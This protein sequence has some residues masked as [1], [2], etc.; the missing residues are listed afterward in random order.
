MKSI[1]RSLS[2]SMF[3]VLFLL[4][5]A[6]GSLLYLYAQR[7]LLSQFDAQLMDKALDFTATSEMSEKGEYEFELSKVALPKFEPSSTAEYY[8]VWGD[9]GAVLLRSPSLEGRDLPR[10]TA[11]A[12]KILLRDISL[13]DGR[14]GRAVVLAFVPGMEEDEHGNSP[15]M[16]ATRQR[17]CLVMARSRA[18]LDRILHVLLLVIILA[19]IGLPAIAGLLVQR[20]ILR[21]LRPLDQV[22][23]QAASIDADGLWR[24]FPVAGMPRELLPICVR[25]NEMFERLEASFARERRFVDNAAHELRTPI[26]EL[27]SLA[28]VALRQ[29]NDPELR[30]T[31]QDALDIAVQ[32]GQLTD[33]LLA[34]ARGES[35]RQPV[36]RS[37][38]DLSRLLADT[39]LRFDGQARQEE[40]SVEQEIAPGLVIE[41]DR[42]LLCAILDNVFSNALTHTPRAGRIRIEAAREGDEIRLTVGNSSRDLLPEDLERLFEPFWRKDAARTDGRHS[43]LGLY[44]V[45]LYARLLEI[46]LAVDMPEAGWFRLTLHYRGQ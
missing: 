23:E 46:E 6:F 13:P 38:V 16:S 25:L 4:V 26:A 37:A 18:E 11:D 17:L 39:W 45:Q 20:L 10:L 3:S 30:E 42:T 12:S 2:L 43:G 41:S 15:V 21:G 8:Q 1:K 34:L 35:G 44:L 7:V 14:A 31:F 40:Q 28:E 29:A 27:R 33:A 32:M 9:N 36:E 5:G 22:A 19:G 24:R